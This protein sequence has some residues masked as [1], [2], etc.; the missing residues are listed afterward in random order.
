MTTPLTSATRILHSTTI[1]IRLHETDTAGRIYFAAWLVRAH[2][3][4]EE[5]LDHTGL[6]LSRAITLPVIF[7][8]VEC[9]AQFHL[10]I[11]LGDRL[12]C[13]LS[14]RDLR[15]KSFSTEIAA[16]RETALVATA[17]LTHVAV[18]RHT[19]AA[20]SLPEILVNKFTTTN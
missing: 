8:V 10:P 9:A 1:V 13:V 5:W 17:R 12:D 18:D 15:E 11:L 16:R 7:P 14:L 6:P 19:G 20:C 2:Q 3:L 4:F